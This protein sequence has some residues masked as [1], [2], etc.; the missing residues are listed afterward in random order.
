M[1]QRVDAPWISGGGRGPDESF[2]QSL[3]N[4]FRGLTLF[5]H[6]GPGAYDATHWTL[7]FFLKGSF[8]IYLVI[9]AMTLITKRCWH[10]VT[11]FLY[12][13][14]W[15]TGDCKFDFA[16]FHP[17]LVPLSSSTLSRKFAN[18]FFSC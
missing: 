11:A 4:L 12:I 15:V 9:L 5:W 1:A 14:C 2:S 7:V 13:Y 10:L 3:I 17:F 8:R 6:N 18:P 16:T